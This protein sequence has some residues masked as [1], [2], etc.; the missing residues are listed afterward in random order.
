[1]A[2]HLSSAA[3]RRVAT[4]SSRLPRPR[5]GRQKTPRGVSPGNRAVEE[6]LHVLPIEW[7]FVSPREFYWMGLNAQRGGLLVLKCS[8]DLVDFDASSLEFGG[9]D[10][11]SVR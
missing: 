1:M 11:R 3:G 5:L 4:L 7:S 10:G 2:G 8:A 9:D 6:V